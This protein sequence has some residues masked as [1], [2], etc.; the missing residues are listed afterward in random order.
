MDEV[1]LSLP[2]QELLMLPLSPPIH[3]TYNTTS[4]YPNEGGDQDHDSHDIVAQETQH[5]VNVDVFYYIPE[6]LYHILDCFFTYA[7]ITKPLNARRPIR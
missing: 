3:V 2:V 1:M 6:T 7:L 4:G 5:I